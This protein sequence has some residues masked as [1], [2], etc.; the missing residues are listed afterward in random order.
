MKHITKNT[1][2]ASFTEWKAQA[3]ADWQPTY[4]ELRTA[5][6]MAVKD[7]LMTEQGYICCYCECRLSDSDSHIEHFRPQS[8][9]SS[10]PLD[11]SNMLC[12]CQNQLN[13]GEPIHCGNSK[14][15]WFNGELLV[16]PF[17]PTCESKFAFTGDGKIRPA[18]DTDN[19]AI[20]SINRLGLDIPKLNDLRAKSI[21]PFLDEDLN[22]EQ[23]SDFVSGYLQI[24]GNGRYGEYWTTI[25][26]LFA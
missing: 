1:E 2:P 8:D 26:Y 7:A 9:S 20:E 4:A 6:K 16:S 18:V 21:E 17:N 5:T 10:D 13:R 22:I 25:R 15:N 24:D 23:M 12:S 19:A 14:G 3:N 11:F